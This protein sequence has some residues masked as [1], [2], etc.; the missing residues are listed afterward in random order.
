MYTS[1]WKD[2]LIST[3]ACLDAPNTE[4]APKRATLPSGVFVEP[5][6]SSLNVV[7][8]CNMIVCMCGLPPWVMASCLHQWRHRLIK[9]HTS[10]SSSKLM[11]V[12]SRG[13]S[14][15]P[16][17]PHCGTGMVFGGMMTTPPD[18]YMVRPDD[19]L[20]KSSI[21][22]IGPTFNRVVISLGDT[23]EGFFNQ[24]K[25]CKKKELYLKQKPIFF[26][27]KQG[28]SYFLKDN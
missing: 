2:Y 7:C 4:A 15:P 8:V 1:S 23:E 28:Y 24:T 20:P 3:I 11:F 27:S 12:Y 19:S 17:T 10:P 6:A 18:Y 14:N 9:T 22:E 16:L 13:F 5:R 26:K 25:A 21:K